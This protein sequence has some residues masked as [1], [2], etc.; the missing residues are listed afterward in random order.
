MVNWN[1]VGVKALITFLAI[2]VCLWNLTKMPF[3]MAFNQDGNDF[4]NSRGIELSINL[5][6]WIEGYRSKQMRT[7]PFNF[8]LVHMSLGITVVV[9]M[10]LSLINKPWRK[11]YCVPFF[12]FSI[13]EGIHAIP[14]SL[15]N[16][17]GFMILF[18]VAC[19]GLIGSG[20]WGF[21]TKANYDKDPVKAEKELTIQYSIVTVI[22]AFAAILEMPNIIS[23][24]SSKK[25]T[26]K[27]LSYGEE[28]KEIFGNTLYDKFSENI[29]RAVFFSFVAIVWF[30]WPLSLVQ[31]NQST[32][33]KKKNV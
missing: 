19:T 7:P 11:K 4:Y 3:Y 26:G 22:N 29:G 9:M 1:D 15:V 5:G 33:A 16:D 17:A 2:P 13:I 28:P 8:L 12:W 10:I 27:F 30:I 32:K 24:L 14:A 6:H 20:I 31:L 18:M 25:E 23:A 21:F